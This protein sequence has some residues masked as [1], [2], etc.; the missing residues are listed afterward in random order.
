M[1]VFERFFSKTFRSNMAMIKP[2]VEKV[3]SI[4]T[5][6][7][8]CPY[9]L[10]TLT[11]SITMHVLKKKDNA[12]KFVLGDIDLKVLKLSP[13]VLDVAIVWPQ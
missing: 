7:I 6:N 12:P 5:A 8:I 4:G 9:K 2:L 13:M 10:E 1:W 11:N 3:L